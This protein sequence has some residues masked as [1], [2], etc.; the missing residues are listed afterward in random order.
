MTKSGLD[1]KRFEAIIDGKK[2]ALYTLQNNNGMEV[3]ISNYG[4][5][6]ISVMAPDRNGKFAN[7]VLG[8]DK[9]FH[10]FKFRLRPCKSDRFIGGGKFLRFLS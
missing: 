9:Y 3:C 1:P 2:T 10:D 6:I 7:V 4:G 5:T 8:Y